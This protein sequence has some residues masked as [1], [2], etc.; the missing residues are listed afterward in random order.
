MR[1]RRDR[2]SMGR[3]PRYQAARPD[4]KLV[5]THRGHTNS[6]VSVRYS[7]D[8]N[9]LISC[10]FDGTAQ[11]W[12]ANRDTRPRAQI[13]RWPLPTADTRIVPFP[14]DTARTEII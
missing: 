12:D 2:T 4:R 8:G 5:L 3:Q 13:G 7:K 9:Y 1:V 10:A 6:S 11:V 14:F